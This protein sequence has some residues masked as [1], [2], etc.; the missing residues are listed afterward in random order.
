MG[1]QNDSSKKANSKIEKIRLDLEKK[2][3][4]IEKL[5]EPINVKKTVIPVSID[6]AAG[7][8]KADAIVNPVFEIS[9]PIESIKQKIKESNIPKKTLTNEIKSEVS[10]IK[11]KVIVSSFNDIKSSNSIKPK[12]KITVKNVKPLVSTSISPVTHTVKKPLTKNESSITEKPEKSKK[13]ILSYLMYTLFIGLFT[14]IGYMAL[15]YLNEDKKINNEIMEQKL[16]EFKNKRYLDSIE[17]ADLS[18]QLLDLQSKKMLDSLDLIYEQELIAVSQNKNSQKNKLEKRNLP[19]KNTVKKRSGKKV[20]SPSINSNDT[21]TVERDRK[22]EPESIAVANKIDDKKE[23]T[24]LV[25]DEKLKITDKTKTKKPKDEKNITNV[26]KSK[27]IKSPVYPGCEKKKTELARKKCLTSKMHRH[28]SRKFNSSIAQ[29]SGL[30]EGIH[31]V[32]VNFI[33]DKEGYATVLNIRGAENDA[34]KKEAERV[35]QSLPKMVPKTIGGVKVKTKF[36][37]PIKYIVEN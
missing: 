1:D 14:G 16:S 17:L 6:S 15:G 3:A 34:I 22:I 19:V 31:T 12:E 36:N 13:N 27:K 33:I 9:E 35:I 5:K 32:K 21:V 28:V 26:A 20:R 24:S 2:L 25:D 7:V 11:E 29:N 37:F 23:G 4:E 10:K 8:A 18:T 30:S